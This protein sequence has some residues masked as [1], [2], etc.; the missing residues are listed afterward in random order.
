M[1]AGARA[2]LMASRILHEGPGFI[3]GLLEEVQSWLE[4]REYESLR[5]LQGSMSQ[6]AVADPS[7]FERANYM[8]TLHSYR[9]G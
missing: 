4:E 8:K 1:L 7:P 2:V 6:R 5:Q 3:P 9:A